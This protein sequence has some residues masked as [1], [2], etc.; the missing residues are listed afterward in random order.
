MGC[1]A[2]QELAIPPSAHYIA[3]KAFFDCTVLRGIQ[4]MQTQKEEQEQAGTVHTDIAIR[5]KSNAG[6]TPFS[7]VV[8]PSQ[9]GDP[10]PIFLLCLFF[11]LCCLA[12]F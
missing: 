10:T 11:V 6:D 8:N 5:A 1:A 3:C 9:P 2:L 4:E 7:E 12:V